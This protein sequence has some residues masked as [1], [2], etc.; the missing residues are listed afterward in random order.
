MCADGLSCTM[1]LRTC[2]VINSDPVLAVH[3]HGY[4]N[5][6]R[7]TPLI[8]VVLGFRTNMSISLGSK[9]YRH[10]RPF[11]PGW[12]QLGIKATL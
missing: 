12:Y 2:A 9:F 8:S 3:A 11:Y 7:F 5:D 10:R 4:K 1:P 6:V